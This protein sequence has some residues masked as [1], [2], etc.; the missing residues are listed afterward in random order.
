M[1][2]H[3]QI[4]RVARR[5]LKLLLG[6]ANDS[7]PKFRDIVRF[8]G[9]D[10][11]DGIKVKSPAQNEPWHFI[12]PLGNDHDVLLGQLSNHYEELVKALKSGDNTKAAFEAAWLSHTIVDGMTPA[13]HFP[14]EAKIE[15]LRGGKDRHSRTSISDK[16][17]FK[18][19][20]KRQT[21]GNMYRVYGPKGLFSSHHLFEFGVMLLLRPLKL[22]EAK[23]SEQELA[24]VKKLGIEEFFLQKAREIAV[25]GLYET[26][27]K[28]GWTA[29]LSNQVRHQLAPT[30]VKTVAVI[31]YDASR[32]A[33]LCE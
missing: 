24:A 6:D 13:H 30:I 19:E 9:R 7:F 29:K 33:G 14:Y 4:D 8:E 20:T 1:G 23:P 3:Q 31:W 17:Y 18:G 27:L 2:A 15:E 21:V 26:Y 28:K 10:G 11:P 5:R 12:E 22:A 16:A 32:K 25:L